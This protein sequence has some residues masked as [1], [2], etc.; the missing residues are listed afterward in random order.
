MLSLEE[1]KKLIGSLYVYDGE[2]GIIV[3]FKIFNGRLTFKIYWISDEVDST[4][5]WEGI[6]DRERIVS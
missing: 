6:D 4:W 1:A 5:N 3:D 2:I